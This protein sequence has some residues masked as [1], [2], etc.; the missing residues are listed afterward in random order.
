M[1]A[2]ARCWRIS[3]CSSCQVRT[4]LAPTVGVIPF[5]GSLH[6][7]TVLTSEMAHSTLLEARF[8]LLG[9]H[10]NRDAQ[11]IFCHSRQ[12]LCHRGMT[13]QIPPCTKRFRDYRVQKWQ[14]LADFYPFF[15]SHHS[16]G[17]VFGNQL[18]AINRRE[19]S[20]T[21]WVSRGTREQTNSGRKAY[22]GTRRGQV[23]PGSG[24]GCRN[25]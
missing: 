1:R 17:M 2:L 24:K 22:R 4:Q 18:C 9:S 11:A 12:V 13:T 3:I 21:I 14:F 25:R 20:R 16:P 8:S 5:P 7:V 23:H 6:N 10:R 15:S 19:R